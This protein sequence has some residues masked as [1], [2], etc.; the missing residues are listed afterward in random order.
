MGE[1]AQRPEGLLRKRKC[2]WK[3]IGEAEACNCG[4]AKTRRNFHGSEQCTRTTDSMV[5]SLKLLVHVLWRPM[6]LW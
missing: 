4:V 3:G 1:N 6:P 2:L 5:M